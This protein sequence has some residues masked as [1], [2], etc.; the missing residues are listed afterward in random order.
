MNFNVGLMPLPDTEWARGKCGFKA[1][2]Y[3]ALGVPPVVSNVG[4]NAEIVDHDERMRMSKSGR[5]EIQPGAFVERSGLLRRLSQRP[6]TKVVSR[7]SVQSNRDNFLRLFPKGP[8]KFVVL[9]RIAVQGITSLSRTGF[10][11]S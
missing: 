7:Y 10:R 9:P 6:G 4:V 11:K 1:L 2:Q 5:M 3:M 8:L